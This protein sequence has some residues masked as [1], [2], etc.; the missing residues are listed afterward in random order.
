MSSFVSQVKQNFIQCALHVFF[1]DINDSYLP[2]YLS[3]HILAI[4]PVQVQWCQEEE[5]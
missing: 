3:I 4:I 1:N 2:T 5:L